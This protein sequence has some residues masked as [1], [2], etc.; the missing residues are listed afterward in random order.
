M[1]QGIEL[2]KPVFVDKNLMEYFVALWL[3][4]NYHCNHKFIMDRLFDASRKTVRKLLDRN[5]L[6][7]EKHNSIVE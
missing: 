6:D 2:G 7:R 5:W 1:L 4:E 3:F